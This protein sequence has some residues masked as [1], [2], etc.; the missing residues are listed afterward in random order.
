MIENAEFEDSGSRLMKAVQAI[1]I[2]PKDA[3]ASVFDYTL[4]ARSEDKNATDRQIKSKVADKIISRYAK[5]AA[6]S[7]GATALAGVIPGVG[8]A[9]A[10]LGGGSV[11]M[12]LSLKFQ[13]DMTM[14][15]AFAFKSGLSDEDAIHM[16]YIIALSSALEKAG[17]AG[18]TKIASKAGVAMVNQYLKGATLQ[19]IKQLFKTIGVTFTRSALTKMIPFGVGVVI[20]SAA[21]YG[22]TKF[23]GNQARDFFLLESE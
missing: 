11:D 12:A 4:Q 20:G 14:C 13:V 22:M 10:M 3:R 1:A 9:A 5:L 18:A 19:F 6:T 7:G 15:L 21:G 2:S 8:T 17:S 23:V 16:S